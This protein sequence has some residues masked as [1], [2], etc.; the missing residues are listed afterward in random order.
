[1]I[2]FCHHKIISVYNAKLTLHYLQKSD[3]Y[4]ETTCL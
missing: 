4:W 3:L 2:F 1:M